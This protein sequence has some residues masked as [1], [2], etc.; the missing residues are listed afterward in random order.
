MKTQVEASVWQ[1]ED[2]CIQPEHVGSTSASG[3]DFL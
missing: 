3:Y 2:R 1:N